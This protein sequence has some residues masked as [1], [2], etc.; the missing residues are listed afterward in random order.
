MPQANR[1]RNCTVNE[2]ESPRTNDNNL[3]VG[4]QVQNAFHIQLE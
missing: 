1:L 4:A 3:E 2:V